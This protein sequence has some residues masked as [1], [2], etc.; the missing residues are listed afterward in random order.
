VI[1][2]LREQ[3]GNDF[4]IVVRLNAKDYVEGGLNLTDAVEIARDLESQRVDAISVTSGTICESV[5]FCL[6]P[7][8]TPKANLLPMAAQ[9]RAA[10]KLPVVVAGRICTPSVAREALSAG[11]TDL[12]GL[13]RPFL[14]DPDWV[15]KTEAGDEKSILL[16]ATCH[17]GC[18]AQIRKG[19]GTTCMFT[20]LINRLPDN[21]LLR[22]PSG[23]NCQSLFLGYSCSIQCFYQMRVERTKWQVILFGST[24]IE[25]CTIFPYNTSKD[26]AQRS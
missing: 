3:V 5:P 8:G 4:P 23:N 7:S 15:R 25:H 9:I 16:C 17:Q 22:L 2:A 1:S 21:F 20:P 12:I 6:Y 11:Q 14:A 24:V 10:I 19:E 13:G 18:L 26:I